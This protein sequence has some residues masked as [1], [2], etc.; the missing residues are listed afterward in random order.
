M[1]TELHFSSKKQDWETPQQLFNKLNEKYHFDLDAAASK[2]N[3]KLENYFTEED[4]SL[5]QDWGSY[6]SIFCNPPYE[7]K[8]QNAFVKKAYEEHQKNGNTIV[9]LLPA[10]V[11]TK[12][13][14]QYIFGKT[15]IQFLEGRLRFENKGVPH[16]HNAP[17]PCAI[18]V[19]EGDLK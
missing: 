16:P 19:Y 7:T 8:L 17:F 12:R 2:E 1:K 3:A 18:V 11:E 15:E 4:D 10:R 9:L 5:V 13:W 14:H 6:N